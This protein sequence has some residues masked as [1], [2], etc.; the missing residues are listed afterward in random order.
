MRGRSLD[1]GRDYA[2]PVGHVRTESAEHDPVI[3]AEFVLF[4][5]CLAV[6]VLPLFP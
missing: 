3:H 2:I 1:V 5:G 6:G 4:D